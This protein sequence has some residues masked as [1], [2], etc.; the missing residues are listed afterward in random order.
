MELL[1]YFCLSGKSVLQ[2]VETLRS[3]S[4]GGGACPVKVGKGVH[5]VEEENRA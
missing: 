2:L 3:L 1:Y 5:R 4:H